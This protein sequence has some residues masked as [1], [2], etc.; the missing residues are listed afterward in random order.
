MRVWIDT[1]F[2]GWH[3]ELISI[4]L[5]AEN[6][7]ELYGVLGCERPVQWV[8]ENV[9]PWLMAEDTTRYRLQEQLWA[10][11]HRFDSVH[12]IADW[13]KDVV[14]FYEL[15]LISDDNMLVTPKITTEL[16]RGLDTESLIPHNAIEDARALKHAYLAKEAK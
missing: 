13:P 16:I 11:L 4:G 3:G 7:E 15:L 9:M 6:G 8:K 14:H 10:F 1:E 12:I 5:T 2:N